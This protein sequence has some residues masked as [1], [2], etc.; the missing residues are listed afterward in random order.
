MTLRN[1]PVRRRYLTDKLAKCRAN[2]LDQARTWTFLWFGVPFKVPKQSRAHKPHVRAVLTITF[3]DFRDTYA[4]DE[5][6]HGNLTW[7]R[8]PHVGGLPFSHPAFETGLHKSFFKGKPMPVVVKLYHIAYYLAGVEHRIIHDGEDLEN[9]AG[10]NIAL[11]ATYLRKVTAWCKAAIMAPSVNGSGPWYVAGQKAWAFSRN[12]TI[13]IS[14]DR[15][16]ETEGINRAP[17][18]V[19]APVA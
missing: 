1:D 13:L 12:E 18:P 4:A 15:I 3:K 10:P 16:E 9:H 2:V 8:E 5:S 14:T 6:S 7:T 11:V 17:Q 19:D